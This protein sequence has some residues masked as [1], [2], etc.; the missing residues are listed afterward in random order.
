MAKPNQRRD[1]SIYRLG[2]E[3]YTNMGAE[4]RKL[5]NE[6]IESIL[7]AASHDYMPEDVIGRHL[8]DAAIGL[9]RR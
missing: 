9:W 1:A 7:V 5:V 4:E 8:M 3:G 6:H 2:K